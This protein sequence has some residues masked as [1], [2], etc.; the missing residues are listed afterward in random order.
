MSMRITLCLLALIYSFNLATIQAM[1]ES[2]NFTDLEMEA[3]KTKEAPIDDPIGLGE[4]LA[5]IDYFKEELKQSVKPGTTLEELRVRY[6]RIHAAEERRMKLYEELVKKYG[7]ADLDKDLSYEIM[8]KKRANADHDRETKRLMAQGGKSAEGKKAEEAKPSDSGATKKPDANDFSLDAIKARQLERELKLE[9]ARKRLAEEEAQRRKELA[10]K[11]KREAEENARRRKELAEKTRRE[12]EERKRKEAEERERRANEI[13]HDIDVKGFRRNEVVTWQSTPVV[14]GEVTGT[15][16]RAQI[17]NYLEKKHG[18]PVWKD[19]ELSDLRILYWRDIVLERKRV[20]LYNSLVNKHKIANLHASMSMEELQKALQVHEAAE[21]QS[22]IEAHNKKHQVARAALF[23]R[24]SKAVF[25]EFQYSRALAYAGRDIIKELP[26]KLC[27]AL[28][29]KMPGIDVIY[30]GQFAEI[31]NEG[32]EL[33]AGARLRV[34][35]TGTTVSYGRVTDLSGMQDPFKTAVETLTLDV[36]SF[37]GT[38]LDIGFN[39]QLLVK[40]QLPKR[41]DSNTVRSVVNNAAKD[42]ITKS[43]KMFEEKM[44]QWNTEEIKAKFEAPPQQH[45]AASL[46]VFIDIE[47]NIIQRKSNSLGSRSETRIP[48]GG[49]ELNKNIKTMLLEKLGPLAVVPERSAADVKVDVDVGVHYVNYGR[50]QQGLQANNGCIPYR[51]DCTVFIDAADT[52]SGKL[53]GATY[54]LSAFRAPPEEFSTGGGMSQAAISQ[55]RALM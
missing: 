40:T 9:E 42:V 14:L 55:A 2:V 34:T 3:W 8:L 18:K 32:E 38:A 10:E 46:K 17:I 30:G 5:L 26:A 48:M 44:P 45:T 35:V 1:E 50:K 19:I 6:W 47:S 4:R 49:S 23:E 54:R 29:K 36:K 51:A 11:R 16:E 33:K 20:A 15:D 53:K 22:A 37:Q 52:Y 28:R 41:V 31:M 13:G 12:V 27:A 39:E 43:L 24:M 21:A 25:V 7:M